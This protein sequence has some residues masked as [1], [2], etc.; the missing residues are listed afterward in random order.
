MII[1]LKDIYLAIAK[2]EM[3]NCRTEGITEAGRPS[4]TGIARLRKGICSEI[5]VHSFCSGIPLLEVVLV[6][7]DE[8]GLG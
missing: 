5:N 8:L 4:R 2:Q 7:S 6:V 3:Q 1:V